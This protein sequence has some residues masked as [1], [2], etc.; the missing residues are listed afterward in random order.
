MAKFSI[1]AMWPSISRVQVFDSEGKFLRKFGQFNV[2][3]GICV[4]HANNWILC[5][6]FH[7]SCAVFSSDGHF[8]T[9]FGERGIA[10]ARCVC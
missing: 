10:D 5:D 1:R 3:L 7:D 2:P 8:I 9:R 6:T 4:D